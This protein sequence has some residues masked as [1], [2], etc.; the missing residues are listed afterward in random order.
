MGFISYLGMVKTVWLITLNSYEFFFK[1]LLSYWSS[2]L[3][4]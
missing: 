3:Y 2:G 4:F 1:A